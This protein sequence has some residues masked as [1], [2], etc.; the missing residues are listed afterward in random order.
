MGMV[1][2]GKRKE[3]G[4]FGGTM[5][6]ISA[7]DFEISNSPNSFS[8]LN[9]SACARRLPS[10]PCFFLQDRS[11]DARPWVSQSLLHIPQFL[12]FFKLD[13]VN[14]GPIIAQKVLV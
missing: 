5:N 12:V 4:R 10:V 11:C 1:S 2:A 13:L 9:N 8:L 7:A 6:N 3:I 14:E